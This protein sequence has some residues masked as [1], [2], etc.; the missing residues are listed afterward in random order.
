MTTEQF[1]RGK[2]KI[3]TEFSRENDVLENTVAGRGFSFEPGFMYHHLN[4]LEID[5]KQKLSDLNFQLLE[6]A[7]ERELKEAK[8]EYDIAFKNAVLAWEL[9]KQ[10]LLSAWSQELVQLKREDSITENLVKNYAIEIGRRAIE[11]ITAKTVIALQIEE[12]QKQL[13]ELDGQTA[14]Y[15]VQLAE[16]KLLTANKKLELL[17]YISQLI[18]V[19]WDILDKDR[20]LANKE[21]IISAMLI[22]LAAKDVLI[23]NK[24][25]E[26]ISKKHDI[27]AAEES[28]I[29]AKNNL[30]T[31]LGTKA[32]AEEELIAA[33]E[34]AQNVWTTSVYPATL[35]L[36]DKMEEYITELAVQLDLYNQISVVKSETA[37][38]KEIGLTKQRAILN[39]EFVL[40]SALEALTVALINLADYKEAVLTPAI[41]ELVN[42]LNEYVNGGA[43]SEQIALRTQIATTRAAIYSLVEQ[44]VEKE[45]ALGEVEES[46]NTQ[47]VLL[48]N[49]LFAIDLLISQNKI[50]S[51]EK[52]LD[53]IIALATLLE[54]HRSE[55]LS[56]RESNFAG[57]LQ[58]KLNE[59]EEQLDITIDNQVALEEEQ[60]DYYDDMAHAFSTYKERDT[61]L[62][63][64]A[65][66]ITAQL[67]HILSQE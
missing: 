10:E 26:L 46:K 30:L 19:E 50:D 62:N 20:I 35:I 11:L 13:A 45:I 43:L 24:L 54:G 2:T 56:T 66:T 64:A 29:I 55:I 6:Q 15:E 18:S 49:A 31:V 34:V 39:A 5:T 61:D 42:V 8:I 16:A 41:A 52:A 21:L 65:K 51:A 57:I 47:R 60:Q 53:N 40:T 12:Y 17:P 14:S 4:N 33:E 27:I 23:A 37:D 48:E 9:E 38:I 63:I 32:D 22:Q 59:A 44:K 25:S 7:V 3:M 28:L 36:L 67:N 1:I 58:F